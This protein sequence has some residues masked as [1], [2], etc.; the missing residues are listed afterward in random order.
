[1]KKDTFKTSILILL[2][3]G[4]ITK[5]LG[6]VIRVL[7]TRT[8][9]DEGI[10]LYTIVT[11]TYSLFIT[12]ATFALPVSISKIVSE[13]TTRSKKI[14]F[15]TVFF[16]LL[17]NTVI[18][19]FLL[20]TAPV[21]ATYLLK[22]PEVTP[23]LYAMAFTLPF[24]SIT[25]ILK[26]Y[27]LGRLQV[28]PNT[29]SN[30][31]EQTVRILYLCFLLP[32]LVEKSVLLGVVSYILFNIV[33]ETVS[34]FV[35]WCFLPKKIHLTKQDLKPD[36]NIVSRVLSISVPSVSSRLIGNIAFF[37]EPI[38][39]TN[40]LLYCGY[41]NAYILEEYASYNAYAI[42]L[43]TMPSFFISAICQIL[44]PEM[45]KYHAIHQDD[46]VKRRLKQALSYSFII[47]L[48]FSFLFFFLRDPILE[49][50]YHTNRGSEYI[51]TLAPF[52]VLFYLEAPLSSALQ[53][54]DKAGAS[55]RITLEGSI[56]KLVIMAL[57]SFCKIG[58]YSLIFSEII[59]IFFVVFQNA[60][61]VKKTLKH[62]LSV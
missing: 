59:N 26:G 56:L 24:I 27:F 35:F 30:I 34:I 43:L 21:I 61:E 40:I 33:T 5:I 42:G 8:I 22:Q 38:L 20:A 23:L 49:I 7:Y 28:A 55:M 9:G 10:N 54:L 41:S 62:S 46:M 2:I 45:S 25:S 37:F 51:F 57:L 16:I 6:F 11:P 32:I 13:N 3:G 18:L 52:F 1:M 48:S 50:I 4:L 17:F 29:I 14:F 60:R 47:G 53:A 58:I 31:F 36:K 19:L 12:L 15:S 44:I 39:L